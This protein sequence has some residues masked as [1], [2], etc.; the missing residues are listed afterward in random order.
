M[1]RLSS[2]LGAAEVFIRSSGESK[3]DQSN[4]EEGR[5][6]A[7]FLLH[8]RKEGTLI[9]IIHFIVTFLPPSLLFFL[10]FFLP[11]FLPFFSLTQV[12]KKEE[13]KEERVKPFH[14]MTSDPW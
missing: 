9:D 7:S 13:G 3:N 5:T 4:D 14:V 1:Y 6:K 12:Y 2:C 11:S 10:S 8:L